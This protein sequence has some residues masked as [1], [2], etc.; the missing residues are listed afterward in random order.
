MQIFFRYGIVIF[1]ARV[2]LIAFCALAQ[3][4][5]AIAQSDW[6]KTIEGAKQEGKVAVS[7]PP[8]AELRKGIEDTFTKRFGV[9]VEL[10]T[11]SAD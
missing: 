9:A 7:I 8:S 2:F 3:T 11:S 4:S 5:S 10:Q 1:A 6:Q